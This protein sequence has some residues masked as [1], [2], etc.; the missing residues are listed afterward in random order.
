[1]VEIDGLEF[2]YSRKNPLFRGLDLRVA[3]GAMCGLLGKNGAGKT[4]LLRI[5][6]GLLF[7]RAGSSRL[8]G[9]EAGKRHPSTMADVFLVPEEFALPELSVKDYV[10]TRAVFY[11]RF[12][13]AALDRALDELEVPGDG[14]LNSYSYGQRKKFLIAFAVAA[15][16]R[17]VLLDEPT[18]GLDIPSK[19]RL[20]K[21]LIGSVSEERCFVISTHQVR[22]LASILDPVVILDNGK[23]LLDIDLETLGRRVTGTTVAEEPAEG[24]VLWYERVPGGYQ[25]LEKNNGTASREVDMELLFNAVTQQ[26][27]RILPILEA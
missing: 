3:P 1:M 21:L 18:N 13:R 15:G 14:R 16:S 6:A 27:Q 23:V 26:P 11:P 2:G 4:S 24:S 8:F 25:V 17:L 9:L 20:R 19:S 7:P 10:D 5:M 22:D 12:D